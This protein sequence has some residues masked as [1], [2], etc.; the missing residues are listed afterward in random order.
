LSD[1]P[2]YVPA[3]L[4]SLTWNGKLWGLP[5]RIDA[6]AIL[7]NK[8]LFREAGLD[9][10]HPPETWPAFIEAARKLTRTRADGHK[11]YGFA[12]TGGGEVGNTLYRSLPFIWMSGGDLLSADMKTA[13]VNQRPAVLGLTFYTDMFLTHKV[14]QP[15]ALADDGLAIRRLFIA[16]S[17]AMYQSGPFDVGPIR[18]ENPGL[19]L[20]VMMIPHP[21]GRDTAVVLGG[22]SFIVPKDS[23]HPKEAKQLVE[24]LTESRNMGVFTDTFPARM[25]SMALPRYA[26]PILENFKRMLPHARKVPQHKHWLQIVQ[27]Y[28]EYLQRVLLRELTPQAA[29]DAAA[30]EI[31]TLLDR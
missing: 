1:R 6:H 25:S 29:M 27:V 16:G 7:F 9:P 23:T 8:T 10:A 14:A 11:E 17:V 31:Q 19:D 5:F 3:S 22:W 30:T 13:V 2:D 28:F 18:Q 26:D 12:I 15:S 21:E 24:F 20:G 4:D